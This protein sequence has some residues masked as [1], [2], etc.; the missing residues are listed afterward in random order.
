MRSRVSQWTKGIVLKILAGIAALA[1]I[2]LISWTMWNSGRGELLLRNADSGELYGAYPVR[3][4]EQFSVGFLHS[5]NK[6]PVIDVY[7]I[8]KDGIYVEKTIYYNFGAGVETELGEGES[9][10]YG[11]DGSMVVS[12][13]DKKLSPLSYFVGT[14]S[15]HTLEIAGES[16]SLRELCGRSSRVE[17]IYQP[18]RHIL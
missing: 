5:V 2:A 12:G 1:V 10:S 16:I 17:F 4:G 15:D 8:K 11:E 3:V 7:E 6:S 13:F 18:N 9:L 14:V